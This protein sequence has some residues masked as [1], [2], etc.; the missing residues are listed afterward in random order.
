MK[1]WGLIFFLLPL[2]GIIY[3]FWCTWS[4]LPLGVPLK[5]AI[6]LM[7][8][9]CIFI[10][11]ANFGIWNIDRMPMPVATAAYEIGN[12]SI[13][14]LLY[15]VL[16]YFLLYVG[17]WV[18]LIPADFMHSS[19]RGTATVVVLMVGLFT[20]G[21]FHYMHKVRQPIILS[22]QKPLTHPL[23]IVM[24][25]DLHIGYHNQV[26]ELNRWIDLINKE[27]P[28][29]ILI[30]GDIIDGHVRPLEDQRMAQSFH[31]LNAPVVACL[32]NH[33]YYTGEQ[34]ALK[35]YKEAGI[36]LLVDSVIQI[37]DINVIGRDD[38]SNPQRKPLELLMAGVDKSK[39]TLLLDHQPYDLEQAEQNGVDFQFS[40][41]THY[42][43]IWPV[44][45]IEDALYEDAYGPLQK[46]RTQYYVTSG[47]GIWGG[48]FRI[49]S[50]SEYLVA[51]LRN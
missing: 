49:G 45:W 32:G 17:R 42:G 22:T 27:N 35:F 34:K 29:L 48:K 36:T 31:H 28:D 39:Y 10:F 14:L 23:K 21:Y 26:D 7:M 46:G 41:H 24:L 51:E 6:L 37:K 15:L 11:F 25:S 38:R 30:G 19:I 40:G 3:S 8:A 43:Q 47:I 13:F 1:P 5:I 50:H 18:H 20:Y 2:I 9:L 16:I 44:S 4:I 12:S 33:E